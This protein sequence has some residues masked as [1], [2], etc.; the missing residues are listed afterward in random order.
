[1]ASGADG[2]LSP[3]EDDVDAQAESMTLSDS[4][5]RRWC[6][7]KIPLFCGC[8]AV[9]WRFDSKPTCWFHNFSA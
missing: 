7:W 2:S 5:I 3:G 6:T 9:I 4:E 8:V 1:M